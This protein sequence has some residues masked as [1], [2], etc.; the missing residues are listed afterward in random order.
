MG[1]AKATEVQRAVVDEPLYVRVR[2]LPFS[3]SEETVAT[4]FDDV[5]ILLKVCMV[6]NAQDK[7][8]GEAFVEVSTEADVHTALRTTAL[9]WAIGT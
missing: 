3:A 7:P 4:F 8:T 1:Q 2:G 6:Y 9:R 5:D